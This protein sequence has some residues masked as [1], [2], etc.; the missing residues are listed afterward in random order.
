LDNKIQTM[1]KFIASLLVLITLVVVLLT[2]FISP[3]KIF[4]ATSRVDLLTA[5]NFAVLGGSAISDV[6]LPSVIKGDVGLWPGGGAAITGLTCVEVTGTIYDRNGGYTGACRVTNNGLLVTAQNDLTT[7]YNDAA[8]RSTTSTIATELGGATLTD[9]VYDS[10]AGTFGITGTLTLN[11]Q[12]NADSVFIF[13]MASTLI[14][15]SSSQVVLINGAQACNVYWQVGSSATLGSSTTLVGNVLASASVVD[16]G[17]STVNGRLL[18]SNGAVTL[19]KTTITKQTCATPTP[20]PSSSSSSST[21]SNSNSS[22]SSPAGPILNYIA[23]II[24]DSRRIDTDS[25]YISWGP[26]SGINTFIVQYGLENGTWLYS[27]NVTGFSTTIHALPPNQPIWVRIAPRD[28]LSIGNYGEAKLVGGPSL[29]NTGFVSQKN[30]LPWYTLLFS[31]ANG[32]SINNQA[33]RRQIQSTT[34]FTEAKKQILALEAQKESQ[35]LPV[36]LEIP[37]INVNADIESVGLTSEGAMGVPH[38]SVNAGWFYLG[39]R[40]GERGSAVIAGHL[41]GENGEPG[42]FTNLYKLK[43]GDRLYIEDGKGKSLV[44][45]VR[46]SR[47]YDPGYADDVFSRNDGA[48]LNLITCDGVWDGTKKS[49]SKRLVVFADITD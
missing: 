2:R 43:K 14:T 5:D 28:N 45:A 26:Y 31:L 16:D 46:E 23:P 1:T 39:P 9:G 32:L 10:A 47:T 11:G 21:S 6:V 27:T 35:G 41:D 15:A 33:E 24:I 19:S 4:A 29:P 36:H 30:G 25:I 40:P 34:Q 17:G 13:K 44:F 18:A 8:G 22:S 7:A 3:P 38:T 49:Y 20:T 37:S 12:G 48:H 42:V